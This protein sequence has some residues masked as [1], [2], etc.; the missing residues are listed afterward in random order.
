MVLEYENCKCVSND[1]GSKET[2]QTL[3]LSWIFGDLCQKTDLAGYRTGANLSREYVILEEA[4]QSS[5]T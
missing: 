2:S 5:Q 3:N 4:S 1:L